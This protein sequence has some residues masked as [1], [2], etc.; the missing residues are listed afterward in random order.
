MFT[1]TQQT[2]CKNTERTFVSS[3][4]TKLFRL[5][6]GPFRGFVVIIV[7]HVV[8]RHLLDSTVWAV[9]VPV[10]RRRPDWDAC[11]DKLVTI[12]SD[13]AFGEAGSATDAGFTPIFR[14]REDPPV[15]GLVATEPRDP[16]TAV[17]PAAKAW[18]DEDT[19]AEKYERKSEQKEWNEHLGR[20]S[21]LSDTADTVEESEASKSNQEPPGNSI[22]QLRDA[23]RDIDTGGLVG[24]RCPP[25]RS[26]SQKMVCLLDERTAAAC[27]GNSSRIEQNRVNTVIRFLSK[28]VN[29]S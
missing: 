18:I 4:S 19:G 25:C 15:D 5:K 28:R 9:E 13:E 6:S 16:A 11:E 29:L 8:S 2:G 21:S 1:L 17:E 26:G 27:H 12:P 22:H 14:R 7:S 23:I 10:L 3:N 20:P 24:H